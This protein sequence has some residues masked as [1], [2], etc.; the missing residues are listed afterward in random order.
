MIFAK[1][2]WICG[3]RCAGCLDARTMGGSIY[4]NEAK[5][6]NSGFWALVRSSFLLAHLTWTSHISQCCHG[7]PQDEGKDG[8]DAGVLDAKSRHSSQRPSTPGYVDRS[9]AVLACFEFV[10]ST[11]STSYSSS[12]TTLRAQV[13]SA[14]PPPARENTGTSKRP[15]RGGGQVLA[16]NGVV[17]SKSPEPGINPCCWR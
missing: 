15:G 1:E 6:T 14:L 12:T 10:A 11:S 17:A 9:G 4:G 7:Y 16:T 3:S 5:L 2:F 13:T 8:L